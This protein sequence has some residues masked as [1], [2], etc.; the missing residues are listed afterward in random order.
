MLVLWASAVCLAKKGKDHWICSLPATFMNAVDVAFI[1]QA[2]IGFNLPATVS[3]IASVAVAMVV[4]GLFLFYTK[5]ETM[6][7]GQ[8]EVEPIT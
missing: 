3:N 2:K 6:L 8:V 1:L 4:F 5:P 7:D